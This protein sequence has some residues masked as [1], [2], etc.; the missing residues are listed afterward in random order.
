MKPISAKVLKSAMAMIVVS[1]L[2]TH[3]V[4]FADDDD[5][6]DDWQSYEQPYGWYPPQP[7]DVPAQPAYAVP[8]PPVYASPPPATYLPPQPPIVVEVPG[9]R[10][11][12]PLGNGDYR[13]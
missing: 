5:D 6:D 13:P 9:L 3:S 4:A 10:V 8:R 2:L 1:L 12:L 11:E 7:A